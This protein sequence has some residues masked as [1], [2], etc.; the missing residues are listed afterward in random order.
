MVS[1]KSDRKT[2][3]HDV[4]QAR[5][6]L[7]FHLCITTWDWDRCVFIS[8]E[9]AFLIYIWSRC[10]AP[11]ESIFHR[12]LWNEKD[13]TRYL[14]IVWYA[15][16]NPD[17]KVYIKQLHIYWIMVLGASQHVTQALWWW[18]PGSC[19]PAWRHCQGERSF[20][21]SAC[22]GC[23]SSAEKWRCTFKQRAQHRGQTGRR[24]QE[25]N[26]AVEIGHNRTSRRGAWYI[27]TVWDE[28]LLGS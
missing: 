20:P 3:S 4:R 9:W 11:L 14:M 16:S 6:R 17:H 28:M 21:L 5:Q 13:D 22:H 15:L 25:T 27:V 2:W 26:T 23:I 7:C 24:A 18:R 10:V 12:S 8:L 1:I 19:V